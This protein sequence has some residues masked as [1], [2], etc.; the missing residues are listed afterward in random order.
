MSKHILKNPRNVFEKS[1][2]IEHIK[3]KDNAHISELLHKSN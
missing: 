2:K 1:R 3:K